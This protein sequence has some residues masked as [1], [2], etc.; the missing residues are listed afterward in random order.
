MN[1]MNGITTA[2]YLDAIDIMIADAMQN[3][4]A[5]LWLEEV[6]PRNRGVYILTATPSAD[7]GSSI[8][9]SCKS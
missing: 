5:E 9:I 8:S 7:A 4:N 2:K 1:K 6:V 3:T